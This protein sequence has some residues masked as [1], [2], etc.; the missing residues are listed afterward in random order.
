[1]ARRIYLVGSSDPTIPTR[2][3]LASTPSQ[4]VAHVAKQLLEVKI[5]SQ[6]D[7]VTHITN[8]VLVESINGESK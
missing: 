1:M 2:L 6:T 4:A 5:A 8:G 7:L 3:V